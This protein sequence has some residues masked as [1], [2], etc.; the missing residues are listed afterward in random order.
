MKNLLKIVAFIAIASFDINCS[1]P[2]IL[3]LKWG[4]VKVE[5]DKICY[6]F[7]DCCLWPNNAIEWNWKITGTQHHPGIQVADIKDFV[8]K[9]DVVILSRGYD[10]VLETKPETI[11]F[12][13]S[14]NKEYYILQSQEAVKLYNKLVKEGKKVGI[15]LHST[16]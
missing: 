6:K 5:M 13:K 16:C 4:E 14:K 15:V 9:V 7:K 12:L 8:D 10:L 2:V 3:G 1:N 11:N